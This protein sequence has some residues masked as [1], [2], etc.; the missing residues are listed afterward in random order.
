[1][2][3]KLVRWMRL[4]GWDTAYQHPL[5]DSWLLDQSRREGRVILTR[6]TKLIRRLNPKDYLFIHHDL[7]PD[8]FQELLS[9]FPELASAYDPLSR[10]VHCND[11]LNPLEKSGAE[12]K[13]WPYVFQTQ[14]K[15]TQCPRCGRI[16]WQATHVKKILRRLESLFGASPNNPPAPQPGNEE[17]QQGRH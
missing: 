4:A 10:C 15:F 6:D 9:A 17:Q 12:G 1:M 5:P 11:P 7:M 16:Y 14:E 13:V 2:L 8:Q 3:G